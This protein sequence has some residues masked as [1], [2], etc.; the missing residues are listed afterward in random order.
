[1]AMLVKANGDITENFKLRNFKHAQ[2]TV[3]GLVEVVYMPDRVLFV[4]EEAILNNEPLNFTASYLAQR[5]IYGD[6]IVLS[7]KEAN[8][9]LN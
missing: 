8:R 3:G 1:M 4:H 7:E 6:A 9:I 2:E 5:D